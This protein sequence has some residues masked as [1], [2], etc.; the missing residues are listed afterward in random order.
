ME[1]ELKQLLYFEG[2]KTEPFSEKLCLSTDFTWKMKKGLF[3]G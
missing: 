2:R 1:V 3:A